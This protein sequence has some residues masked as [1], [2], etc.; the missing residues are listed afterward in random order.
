[1]L[2]YNINIFL[3]QRNSIFDFKTTFPAQDAGEEARSN[4]E[5]PD[6]WRTLS[7]TPLSS[8]PVVLQLQ[9]SLASATLENDLLQSKVKKVVACNQ[10]DNRGD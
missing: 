7:M 2:K 9:K 10:N 4:P 5:Y 6:K 3:L 8:D 1:M